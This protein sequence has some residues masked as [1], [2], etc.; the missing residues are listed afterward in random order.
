[1][2]CAG[3]RLHGGKRDRP[4]GLVLVL[5][6]FFFL[7]LLALQVSHWGADILCAP[8]QSSAGESKLD[9]PRSSP[10]RASLSFANAIANG[11]AQSSHTHLWPWPG[12]QNITIG[13]FVMPNTPQSLH[14]EHG[15]RGPASG[16]V[17]NSVTPCPAFVSAPSPLCLGEVVGNPFA[18]RRVRSTSPRRPH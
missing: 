1:M 11:R 13:G 5:V 18:A 9:L 8:G 2:L 10:P 6:L 12:A 17:V 3:Y 4:Q 7:V 14:I 16:T 15:V